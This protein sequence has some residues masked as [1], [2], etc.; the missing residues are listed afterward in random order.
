MDKNEVLA[1][2]FALISAKEETRQRKFYKKRYVINRKGLKG[3]MWFENT[4]G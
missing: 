1:K 4:C 2:V 3:I